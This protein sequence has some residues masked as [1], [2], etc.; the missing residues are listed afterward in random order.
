MRFT[1]V[2][3]V[4][5]LAAGSSAGQQ[6]ALEPAD[7]AI[8]VAWGFDEAPEKPPYSRELVV[9]RGSDSCYS[10][11]VWN[12]LTQPIHNVTLTL[13]PLRDAVRYGF[14]VHTEDEAGEPFA[15]WREIPANDSAVACL[16]VGPGKNARDLH[17]LALVR[18]EFE[19][20]TQGV[21]RWPKF[22]MV[23]EVDRAIVVPSVL[24][25]ISAAVAAA[26]LHNL[27]RSRL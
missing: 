13:H 21:A 4:L 20:G 1:L 27:R 3:W 14:A 23:E 24:G 6:S 17:S 5:L 9:H 10:I 12:T 7:G 18:F 16:T 22:G 25:I 26:V 19:N 2:L 15:F 8:Y 11:G